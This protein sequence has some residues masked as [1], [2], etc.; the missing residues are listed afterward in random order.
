MKG[1]VVREFT[2]FDRVAV[3]DFADPPCAKLSE[4]RRAGMAST[5]WSI[6]WAAQPMPLLCGRW[7]GADGDYRLRCSSYLLQAQSSGAQVVSLANA[8][9]DFSNAMKQAQE[10]GLTSGSQSIAAM[11]VF[12][13]TS[14][15]SV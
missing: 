3:G 6:R 5:S 7:R 14:K 12:S 10:F 11:L 8:G 2:P 15:R 4:R 13:M 1:A 9:T